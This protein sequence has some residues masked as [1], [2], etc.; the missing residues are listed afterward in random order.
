LGVVASGMAHIPNFMK[1]D[2]NVESVGHQT[3]R[4]PRSR[5]TLLRGY[6]LCAFLTV[7]TLY[8]HIVISYRKSYLTVIY[9]GKIVP[10]LN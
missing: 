4:D 10:V 7:V 1:F 3:L 2:Q 6:V 5:R 8:Q 9:R